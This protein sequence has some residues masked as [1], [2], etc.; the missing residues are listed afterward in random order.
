[1]N[2]EN[3]P[4]AAKD[5]PFHVMG[6]IKGRMFQL[7]QRRF[8][9]ADL[10]LGMEGFIILMRIHHNDGMDQTQLAESIGR[11]KPSVTRA[12]DALEN[13]GWLLR[14]VNP[15][16]RRSHRLTLTE[17]GEDALERAMPMVRGIIAQIFDPIPDADYEVFLSVLRTLRHQLDS[18]EA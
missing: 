2:V 8:E 17:E 12:L 13:N 16:D 4:P 10:E 6:R 18:L 9:E 11:D 5:N 1:M 3:W 15:E 7:V 14:A